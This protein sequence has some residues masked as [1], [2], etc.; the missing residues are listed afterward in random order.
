MNGIEQEG[1]AP[2]GNE[3]EIFS[4]CLSGHMKNTQYALE[5]LFNLDVTTP[6]EF[7]MMAYIE[8]MDLMIKSDQRT[9]RIILE[10]LSKILNK[11]PDEAET[12]SKRKVMELLQ[13]C[14]IKMEKHESS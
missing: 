10:C 9:Q 1:T 14:I 5:V 7:F 8:L 12:K 6:I 3:V 11:I 13:D 4:K 2:E